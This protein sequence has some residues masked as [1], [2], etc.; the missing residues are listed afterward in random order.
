MIS[1]N[2]FLVRIYNLLSE[3]VVLYYQIVPLHILVR[4]TNP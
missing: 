4:L 3:R 2:K 1:N